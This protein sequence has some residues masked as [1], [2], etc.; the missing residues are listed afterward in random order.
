MELGYKR[1]VLD[2]NPHCKKWVLFLNASLVLFFS[3]CLSLFTFFHFFL[4]FQ[5]LI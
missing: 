2:K 1:L 5:L 3:N 4:S